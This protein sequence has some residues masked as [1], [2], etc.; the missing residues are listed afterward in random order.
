MLLGEAFDGTNNTK[1]AIA[2][3]S[4]AAAANPRPT[5]RSLWTRVSLL[6]EPDLE[7]ASPEFQKEIQNDANSAQSYA[8]LGDIAYRDNDND[9]GCEANFRRLSLF[10]MTCDSP[11]LT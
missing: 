6:E 5:Q 11:T 9:T 1:E 4:A 7:H 8:Y 3:F 2:E 10:A